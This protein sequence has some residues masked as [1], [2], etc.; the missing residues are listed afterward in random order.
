MSENKKIPGALTEE[1]LELAI[2]S[3]ITLMDKMYNSLAELKGESFVPAEP[4]NPI[5]HIYEM[6]AT[7]HCDTARRMFHADKRHYAVLGE[8]EEE[9]Y[10][11][12]TNADYLDR[13][14]SPCEVNHVI[15]SFPVEQLVVNGVLDTK[16]NVKT[17]VV[18]KD[19]RF[20]V[21]GMHLGIHHPIEIRIGGSGNIQ[22]V[23][24]TNHQS[25]LKRIEN[26]LLDVKRYIRSIDRME[27]C[28][29]YIPA[30][31][32][33]RTHKVFNVTNSGFNHVIAF[34]DQLYHIE[35]F[36]DYGSGWETIDV[37][38][39][40]ITYNPDRLTLI[41][42]RIEGEL[43]TY[44][45]QVYF[46]RGLVPSKVRIDVL[47]TKGEVTA[48]FADLAPNAWEYHW[49]DYD[50]TTNPSRLA[51]SRFNG[52]EVYSR[53]VVSG[54]SNEKTLAEFKNRKIHNANTRDKPITPNELTATVNDMGFKIRLHS[55]SLGSRVYH[56]SRNLPAPKDLGYTLSTKSEVETGTLTLALALSELVALPHV[57]ESS[58]VV[59]IDSRQPYLIGEDGIL[60]PTDMT[61]I[62]STWLNLP[63]DRITWFNN[64]RLVYSPFHY[65]L[66]FNHDDLRI[67][68]FNM[69]FPVTSNQRFLDD[70]RNTA[71]LL[72]TKQ[73]TVTR[74]ESGYR[75]WVLLTGEN[76]D[77]LVPNEV[78][79][80]LTVTPH[81]EF[82]GV[83]GVA[84]FHGFHEEGWV[85][86]FD[87]E[88]DNVVRLNGTVSTN[89]F[90]RHAN[91]QSHYLLDLTTEVEL[92]I[93][94]QY[95]IPKDEVEKEL[96]P[97]LHPNDT[98]VITHE[99]LTLQLGEPMD[100]LVGDY[101]K[102]VGE[103]SYKLREDSEYL[104]F[105]E[106]VPLRD[107]EGN[108]VFENDEEGNLRLQYEY[109][110]G[111][112]MLFG[113]NP[114]PIRPAG[115]PLEEYGERV[116]DKP[117][118]TSVI[119]DVVIINGIYQWLTSAEQ[120][121]F[122]IDTRK[123]L[124]SYVTNSM[125]SI[126]NLLLPETFA[127]FTPE[128]RLRNVAVSEA[129]GVVESV[130]GMLRP[131]LRLYVDEVLFDDIDLRREL[132]ETIHDEIVNWV[133]GRRL[134]TLAIS[135]RIQLLSENIVAVSAN[136][137]QGKY[138]VVSLVNDNERFSLGK[139]YVYTNR[140]EYAVVDDFEVEWIKHQ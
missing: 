124:S 21:S 27:I 120:Q 68:A 10:A 19:S 55:D 78:Q 25:E 122:Y 87:L 37:S 116:V 76:T 131:S 34:P 41:V 109:R 6:T 72:N 99:A 128:Q 7:L 58:R 48:N 44:L 28:E 63:E 4:S 107:E 74:T 24:L 8:T 125:R 121:A 73:M 94:T 118:E 97:W 57:S 95:P 138:E 127:Y 126:K 52:V 13:F 59:T 40:V 71:V 18:G 135:E 38:H 5:N 14:A 112:V 53:A 12:L 66:D 61:A 82:S 103:D 39:S 105:D 86:T 96:V 79:V 98:T 50:N 129:K 132:L 29:V 93:V 115:T 130:N 89:S 47:S 77:E 101:R 26:N 106:D 64:H 84:K 60:K 83:F 80:Q 92:T 9:L 70:N 43:H 56:V 17:V 42:K 1:D 67:K 15:L 11:G 108:M 117:G 133:S 114:I 123:K 32:F 62:E 69:D 46:D 30:S 23:W 22:A 16:R 81:R 75:C 119:F 20:T 91:D 102:V 137:I 33:T 45:P 54:G 2:F 85:Y 134:S 113:G 51:L 65:S 3:P 36:V 49:Q 140:G 104:T 139:R 111:E 31:Q 90:K 136:K 100:N 110:K 35:A 88:T